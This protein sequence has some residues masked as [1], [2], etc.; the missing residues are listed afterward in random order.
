MPF[1]KTISKGTATRSPFRSLSPRPIDR[2]A[3]F[4]LTVAAVWTAYVVSLFASHGLT[5]Q[6]GAFSLSFPLVGR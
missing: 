4:A 2:T 1:S 3:I 6:A 5:L